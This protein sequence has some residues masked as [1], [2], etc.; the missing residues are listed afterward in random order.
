[1]KE[2]GE[3]ERLL[4]AATKGRPARSYYISDSEYATAEQ[5]W[6]VARYDA[7]A[8]IVAL[9]PD[10]LTTLKARD[11]E[12]EGLRAAVIE[13]C[14]K[15]CEEQAADF[16]SPE[17]ATGQ[18]LSSAGERVACGICAEAIRALRTALSAEGTQP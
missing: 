15:V 10:L 18:P 7:R 5:R 3:L 8:A 1:M 17:Y 9:L 2:L 12:I 14:A 16:L 13:E 4:A 11:A 6:D